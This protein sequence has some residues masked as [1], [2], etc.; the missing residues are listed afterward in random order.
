VGCFSGRFTSGITVSTPG[1]TLQA[2]PGSTAVFDFSGMG[3][4]G[5][6]SGI[7][8]SASNVT[9]R[10]MEVDNLYNTSND[11]ATAAIEASGRT[12]LTVDGVTTRNVNNAVRDTAASG[13]TVKNSDLQARGDAVIN[14]TNGNLSANRS[15]GALGAVFNNRI[16]VMAY[17]PSAG[18]VSGP[19]GIQAVNGLD[20]HDNTFVITS[21]SSS[22]STQHP[23]GFQ[24][25][26]DF[27][28][29]YDNTFTDVGDSSLDYDAFANQEINDIWIFN[30]IFR[31]VRNLDPYPDFVRLYSS[32]SKPT[33]ITNFKIMNNVFADSDAG[34]GVPP[35]NLCFYQGGCNNPST[36]GNELSNNIFVNDGTAGG[37]MLHVSGN[38]GSAWTASHN[39][40]YRSSGGNIVWLGTTYTRASFVTNVDTTGS[41][42]MPSFTGYVPHSASNDFELQATDTVAAN[43]GMSRS[44]MFS[45]DIDGV[46]RPQGSAWD[47]GPHERVGG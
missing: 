26:G 33:S 7:A 47:R 9:L 16:N 40:Y 13:V 22:V 32:G 35:V 20:V 6:G 38:A 36:S 46:A 37:A 17:T 28:R 2:T 12:G 39:V 10:G 29:V 23:D 30:N 15:F 27:L 41:T 45:T 5:S 3:G 31:I 14:L 34:G 8:V 21:M 42:S 19:D 1:V 18:G 44:T 4:N 25:Q 24:M 11:F 43:T